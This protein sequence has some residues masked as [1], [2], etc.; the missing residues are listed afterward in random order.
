MRNIKILFL[1]I[2]SLNLWGCMKDIKMDEFTDDAISSSISVS[3]KMPAGY[4]YSTEDLVVKLVDPSSGLEFSEITN[5][6]GIATIR[7][8]PGTYIATTETKHVASGGVIYIFNGTSEKVRVTPVDPKQVNVNLPL[9]VS[10]AGQIVIKEFYYGGCM[11]P[12]TGKSYSKDQYIILY[13][14][15]D[16]VAYLDSL[17]VGV[18]DPYNAPTNGKL[19]VWVKGET[20]ELRDSVP[21]CG[22]GWMFPGNGTDNP[23]QPGEETVIS[24]NA[25]NHNASVSTSVN[26]GKPGYWALYDPILTR[27]QSTPEPGVNLLQGFWKVGTAT[28]YVVSQSSPALFIYSLGG[29]TPAQFVIDTYTWKPGYASNRNFDCLMADKNLILDGVECFRNATDSKRLRPE[30][31]NGFAMTDGSG[32]GQSVHRKID[33]T[34]TAAAGGRI[35]YMDTNNS[36]NDF[37]KRLTASLLNK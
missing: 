32:Q 8:A 27:N 4:D 33:A 14:N 6:S 31:D 3:V 19:S 2:A 15:S 10:R 30:I 17:C 23:L 22:I 5:Q 26:L 29:K 13:N 28:S 9:N 25:I 1:L 20:T 21:V 34:A 24:L 11:D 36:S 37:E 35:V 18:V 12:A 16:E 7:V